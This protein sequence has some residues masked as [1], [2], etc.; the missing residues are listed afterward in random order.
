MNMI[1]QAFEKQR[2]KLQS[3]YYIYSTPANNAAAVQLT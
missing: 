3:E 1:V 2:E